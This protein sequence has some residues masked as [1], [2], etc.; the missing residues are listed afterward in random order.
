M[1]ASSSYIWNPWSFQ[2]DY[3]AGKR[4]MKFLLHQ[5]LSLLQQEIHF[6]SYSIKIVVLYNFRTF[7][8]F[9]FIFSKWVNYYR[10]NAFEQFYEHNILTIFCPQLKK[11][12]IYCL[13]H[14]RIHWHY[15]NSK[16]VV[17]QNLSNACCNKE[18]SIVRP[19]RAWS[20]FIQKKN[21][22]PTKV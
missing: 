2:F 22:L 14:C 8:S 17:T 19:Y 16:K 1:I 7:F 13:C 3:I 10:P 5:I 4:K 21:W 6:S 12:S 9:L 20:K 11:M 15:K 18:N